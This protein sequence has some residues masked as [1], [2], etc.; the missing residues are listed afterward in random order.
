MT[1]QELIAKLQTMDPSETVYAHCNFEEKVEGLDSHFFE[2]SAVAD[3]GRVV[4][5]EN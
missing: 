5:F 4:L 3:M 1:V 2:I